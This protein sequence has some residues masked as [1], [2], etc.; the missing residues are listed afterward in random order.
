MASLTF[1]ES[2]ETLRN[3]TVDCSG[4]KYVVQRGDTLW[5]IAAKFLGSGKEWPRIYNHNSECVKKFGGRPISNP[6]RIFP[7][8]VIIV[9]VREKVS[10]VS[11]LRPRGISRFPRKE[12]VPQNV[13]TKIVENNTGDL[14]SEVFA[15]L[16]MNWDD[17]KDLPAILIVSRI[18][19]SIPE[20]RISGFMRVEL[21]LAEWCRLTG[22]VLVER[23]F[24][25]QIPSLSKP[26]PSFA[27]GDL[28][29][30]WM[31]DKPKKPSS[32]IV[33][34]AKISGSFGYLSVK[35]TNFE[36]INS[37]TLHN[38]IGSQFGLTSTLSDLNTLTLMGKWKGPSGA[39]EIF[40]QPS[41]DFMHF[42]ED[43]SFD[44]SFG[45]HKLK[46]GRNLE[47]NLDIKKIFSDNKQEFMVKFKYAI[48]GSK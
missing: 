48:P 22:H 35:H 31:P 34:N 29:V 17:L 42:K 9:P 12:T 18:V 45:V 38:K 10:A 2:F 7:G 23:S 16:N 44:M 21:L 14:R 30:Q 32:T 43:M 20:A 25:I 15:F 8:D 13:R 11:S 5:G 46:L 37:V 6:N 1:T 33:G 27:V 4:L 24:G 28:S 36:K 41:V 19:G 39:P 47:M 3:N 40:V 26:S